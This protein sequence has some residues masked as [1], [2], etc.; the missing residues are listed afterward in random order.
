VHADEATVKFV[1]RAAPHLPAAR[2][3]EGP[4]L[5]L[6][7]PRPPRAAPAPVRVCDGSVAV[8]YKIG[9]GEAAFETSAYHLGGVVEN[10][11]PILN[12]M[13]VDNPTSPARCTSRRWASSTGTA[14]TR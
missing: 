10:V 2:E 11:T 7:L 14:P 4:G 5:D 12:A 8:L 9:A 13:W 6:E 3:G 1:T